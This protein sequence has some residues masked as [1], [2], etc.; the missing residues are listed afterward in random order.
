MIVNPTRPATIRIKN[1]AAEST[2]FPELTRAPS[3]QLKAT[4]RRRDASA[5]RL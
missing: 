4:V 1:T 3:A 2:L 5:E